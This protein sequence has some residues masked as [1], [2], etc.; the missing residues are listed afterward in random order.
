MKQ[1]EGK[2]TSDKIAVGSIYEWNK[3]TKGVRQYLTSTVGAELC[4]L[5]EGLNRAEETLNEVF[6]MACEYMDRDKAFIFEIHKML[7]RDEEFLG[8]IR[9]HITENRWSA[10]YA[11]LEAKEYYKELFASLEDVALQNRILDLQDVITRLLEALDEEEEYSG[12]EEADGILLIEEITPEQV[13]LLSKEKIQ[14]IITRKGTLRSHSAIVA[15][16]RDIPMLLGVNVPEH[17]HGQRAILDGANAVLLLDVDED[18]QNEY[19]ERQA[20]YQMELGGMTKVMDAEIPTRSN[21]KVKVTANISNVEEAMRAFM[22]RADG[23]GLFR[24]EFLYLGRKSAPSFEEQTSVYSEVVRSMRGREVVIRTFDLGADKRVDYMK[25]SE[26]GNPALGHRGIRIALDYRE[27]FRTQLKAILVAAGLGSVSL[28][29]PM[30]SNQWEVEEAKKEL[31]LAKKELDDMGMAY[32]EV[33]FGIMIETPAAALLAEELAKQVDFFSI[34]TNDLTQYV[35]GVD[36]QDE[37]VEAYYDP[38]H[39]AVL[40]LMEKVIRK[41]HKVGIKVSVC[42]ELAGNVHM[43]ERLVLMGV[44][45]LSVVPSQLGI[46]KKKVR[47]L[48]E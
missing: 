15:A 48:G 6:R 32:G 20:M 44:D 25:L 14:G 5:E 8:R 40:E 46:I 34:G 11:V 38:T 13:L 7:L 3:D 23:I 28:M 43:T 10:E 17:V 41:A 9:K 39:P 24:S 22:N 37:A 26:E 16:G 47:E 12:L 27:I 35:L 18:T 30:V 42:G 21:V 33:G 45:S 29:L 36:R 31:A 2:S 1:Y 19:W 4:R